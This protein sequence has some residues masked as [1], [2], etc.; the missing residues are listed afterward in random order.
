MFSKDDPAGPI[1]TA[2]KKAYNPSSESIEEVDITHQFTNLLAVKDDAEYQNIRAAS[3]ACAAIMKDYFVNEMSSIIDEEKKV[4]HSKLCDKVA[5][6]IDD[7]KFFSSKPFQKLAGFDYNQL[8]WSRGPLVQS[9][10]KYDFKYSAEPD[11]SNLQADIIIAAMGLKYRSYCAEVART[12]LIDPTKQQD[13]YYNFLTELSWLVMGEMRAGVA[14]KDI[15]NA[16]LKEI[17]S[18]FPDLEKNF[19]KSVGYGVGIERRE[20]QL[21]LSAKNSRPLEDGMVFTVTVGFQN[22]ENP[23]GKP[24]SLLL[25]DT[26]KVSKGDAI[27]LTGYSKTDSKEVAFY[28]KDEEQEV[29]V[30]EKKPASRSANN[31]A[32]L[33]SK[34]RAERKEIDENAEQRRKEHQK[35]LHDQKQKEGLERF[36]K[37]GQA[38]NGDTKKTFKRF[39][40]YK[41][42]GQLP[43]SVQD[44]KIVVD[45][46]NQT[47]IV[48]IFGRP[49]PF[50][51]ATIKNASVSDEDEFTHLRI[52]F[53]S[54]GQGVGRKDDLPFE[55]VNAHFLRSLSFKSVHKERMADIA[56]QITD[57]KKDAIRQEQTRKEME[58]VVTQDNLIEIRNRRPLKLGEVFV[59]PGLDGKRVPGELE[60]HQNGLRYQ[61]P[62]RTD[63]RIDI[64]FSN[65]KHLFFQP[66]L[67]ELIVIIHVHLK[68]PIMIGK[69]KSKD[70]QF[71]REAT[72]IQFDE[73][74]N[75]KR[76]YRYGDEEE[77]EAEQEEKRRRAALDKEFKAFAEKIA[78]ATKKEA[79]IGVDIPFRE[80]GFNGVPFRANV[81][82]CPTT[83]ALVQ[84]T[85][86][87]FLVV[88]LDEIEIAHL[89]RVQFGLK[90]FDMV[91]VY[92]D[93]SRPV[94]H[95]N[96]IPME[97]LDTVKEW[98]DSSNIPYSEGPLNLNWPTIMKTVQADTHEFFSGGGWSFLELGDDDE[99]EEEEEEESEFEAES[100]EGYSDGSDSEESDYDDDDDA[101]ED[102]GSGVSDDDSGGE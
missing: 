82:C 11:D 66:C 51:I 46:R 61:S 2:W 28:F 58:D 49:V 98:L 75:R 7:E 45:Q 52:N 74:G 64:L 26:V 47:V 25:T 5:N 83:D 102:E 12:Y 48:P 10:G 34:L 32:V 56:K 62:L 57:M 22:L 21:A 27:I 84:L 44:L 18:K 73:T 20:S 17:K 81:L 23:K 89:E 33:K 53:L 93:F 50:H 55:D 77:Y 65:V 37:E 96:T 39:E 4:S 99:D 94:T 15:Y 13:Q 40:S 59:R 3:K 60:I 16:A 6:K 8:E 92:K 19:V 14:C 35:A 90:N 42:D 1:P 63:H 36:P 80:L 97:S 41:R 88:T 54:P 100:E 95:V 87:P 9:G 79:D 24:Y 78:D 72:D 67:H 85:D 86:P 43:P 69:K 76:K 31:S 30:K 38:G 29:K 70:V 71:Y 91:F 68:D 101:S